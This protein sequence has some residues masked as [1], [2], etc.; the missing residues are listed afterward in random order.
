MSCGEQ[1]R[2]NRQRRCAGDPMVRIA[3]PPNLGASASALG[4][5][6]LRLFLGDSQVDHYHL[7]INYM[8]RY[9]ILCDHIV[10]LISHPFLARLIRLK[11]ALQRDGKSWRRGQQA[12]THSFSGLAS[13]ER[14]GLAHAARPQHGGPPGPRRHSSAT[15]SSTTSHSTAPSPSTCRTMA[16]Q[17][18]DGRQ[19]EAAARSDHLQRSLRTPLIEGFAM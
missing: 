6:P 18:I 7:Y 16:T 11:G 14:C 1:W 15:Y 10:F 4:A 9:H 12:R 13:C 8:H 5:R 17:G 2:R 19:V 3:S